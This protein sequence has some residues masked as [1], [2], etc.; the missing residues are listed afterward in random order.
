M[1]ITAFCKPPGSPSASNELGSMP[2]RHALSTSSKSSPRHSVIATCYIRLIAVQYD[3]PSIPCSKRRNVLHVHFQTELSGFRAAPGEVAGNIH[4]ACRQQRTSM[5]DQHRSQYTQRSAKDR[6]I[7]LARRSHSAS[8][9]TSPQMLYAFRQRHN[10][11]NL[12][13]SQ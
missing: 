8:P 13:L 9:S 3:N 10:V 6:H 7:Y 5:S 4:T 11:F 2:Q 1:R 12:L